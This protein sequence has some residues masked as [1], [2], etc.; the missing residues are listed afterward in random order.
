MAF[1]GPSAAVTAVL[2]PAPS[3]M[4]P[5]PASYGAAPSPYGAGT[6]YGA[7]GVA[8]PA[9]LDLLPGSAPLP[10]PNLPVDP[11]LLRGAF[12]ASV[13]GAPGYR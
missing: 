5:P 7:S 2:P 9:R 4:A 3:G 1:T 8:L 10:A 11:L 12:D 6:I 13:Y